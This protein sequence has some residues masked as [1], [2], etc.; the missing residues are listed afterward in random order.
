MTPVASLVTMACVAG[1]A[2]Q[3][4]GI[5]VDGRFEDWDEATVVV[6]DPEDAPADAAVDLRLARVMDD[7]HYIYIDLDVGRVVTAQAMR[8]TV[9]LIFDGDDD[10][11]TGATLLGVAGA[12]VVLELSR[13]DTR[14]PDGY[15]GGIGV[16]SVTARG[17]SD[18]QSPYLGDVI[19]SPQYSSSRFEIR[20]ARGAWLEGVP[21]LFT[22]ARFRMAVAFEDNAGMRDTTGMGSY[23]LR[24]T[25]RELPA[26]NAV[27]P[28][29]AQGAFRTVVWNVA[30]E[31]FQAQPDRAARVLAAVQPDVIML[32]ELFGTVTEDDLRA[33]FASAPL[34]AR[35]P[36]SF[37][38]GRSGGR[39]R[40]AVASV[41]PIRAEESL[42]EVHYPE[43]ALAALASRYDDPAFHQ[44]L[45]LEAGRGL[46]TTGA[47]VGV[48][49][50]EV[51]F[52]PLD[53]QS[54]GHDGS[55]RDA[56]REVQA[57]TLRDRVM[58]AVG[59]G[60]VVV[61][62]DLNLV[63]SRRPLD[64]LVLGLDHGRDLVVAEAWRLGDRSHTT[65]RNPVLG[66]FAPGR[67][68]LIM[69]SGRMLEEVLAF[70]FDLD[71]LGDAERSRHGLRA[72]D[73]SGSDHLP[74]V[75]DLRVRTE[76]G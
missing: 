9:S 68:D 7:P 11:G 72:A 5:W 59:N 55:S 58:D 6:T 20:L 70:N 53:F 28:P 38:L 36:W 18:V 25:H 44:L 43:G 56:L 30:G 24:T 50:R 71:A 16:R 39:Q 64:S 37:V 61:G 21:S 4:D 69:Y 34:A 66:L 40:A 32:D 2:Q 27:I 75:V 29:P 48:P 17:V 51:L 23:V 54:V 45:T 49:G 19:A 57:A 47:W 13:S 33:F 15:G 12:D 74:V 76:P 63:G 73:G 26:P 42:Q 35:G 14:Q 31:R 10:V 22:A 46:S 1:A 65:W 62:G 60:A 67:L 8:G 41:H 52:V 3:D